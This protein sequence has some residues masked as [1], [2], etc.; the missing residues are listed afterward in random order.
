MV[1]I[2][3]KCYSKNVKSVVKIQIS[4]MYGQHK[5][6]GI[7]RGKCIGQDIPI[8][9]MAMLLKGVSQSPEEHV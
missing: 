1:Y 8:S 2:D 7:D 9:A 4:F 6:I 3:N 5:S